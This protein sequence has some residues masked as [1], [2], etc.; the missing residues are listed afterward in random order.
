MTYAV[1][2]LHG[3]VLGAADGCWGGS[4]VPVAATNSDGFAADVLA[5][6]SEVIV[7]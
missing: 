4:V 1:R 6:E 7:A 2:R 5:R 3:E